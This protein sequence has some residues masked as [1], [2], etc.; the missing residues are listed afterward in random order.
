ML[1]ALRLLFA[2]FTVVPSTPDN[3]FEG[4][5]GG[6]QIIHDVSQSVPTRI[7]VDQTIENCQLWDTAH[8]DAFN[9]DFGSPK[10]D[11]ALLNNH[12]AETNFLAWKNMGPSRGL[13]YDM[14]CPGFCT[15]EAV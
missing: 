11:V 12:D 8:P 15:L 5:Y 4:L 10:Y 14:Y 6:Y 9:I 13:Y 1:T 7:R 3:G 2:A